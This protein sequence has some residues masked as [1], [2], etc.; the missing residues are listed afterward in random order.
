[1]KNSKRMIGVVL[2]LA[3]CVASAFADHKVNKK[4]KLTVTVEQND[5][6]AQGISVSNEDWGDRQ[7]CTDYPQGAGDHF[8]KY[9]GSTVEVEAK[10]TF[11]GDP[12]TT[13]PIAIS[14]VFKVGREKIND[15][16][17]IKKLG[18]LAGIAMAAQGVDA[19]T[20][21]SMA[22]NPECG[23]TAPPDGGDDGDQQ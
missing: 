23:A 11:D 18:L 2:M 17:A 4:Q 8:Q 19:Q 1:M 3:V 6:C 12:K 10:W 14:K 7:L 21:A 22:I 13:L 9:V 20:A 5:S 15:P 16:C